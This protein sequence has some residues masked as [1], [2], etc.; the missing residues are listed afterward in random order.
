MSNRHFASA[1][2]AR[3]GPDAAQQA[4][5]KPR[6]RFCVIPRNHRRRGDVLLIVRKIIVSE[7]VTADG[8]IEAPGG[9]EPQFPLGGWA[10]RFEQGADGERFK[11]DEVMSAGALL[12]GRTTYEGLARAWPTF[13]PDPAGFT[14]RMNTMTKYVVSTTLESPTWKN[15]TVIGIDDVAQLKQQSGGDLL[16]NGSGRLVQ[17][18]T[19]RRLV[20]E[21][22]LMIF[23]IVLGAGKTLF[24]NIR[25]PAAMRVS[26]VRRIG[27]DGIVLVTYTPST[28]PSGG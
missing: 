15:T 28:S 10:F 20:D 16:I 1:T 8:V 25:E 12:L 19:D 4:K 21:Y 27:S 13:P 26:D 7:F 3:V 2:F 24:A 23:P 5:M 18:L 9:N 17:G 11:L 22:R 14:E 6:P